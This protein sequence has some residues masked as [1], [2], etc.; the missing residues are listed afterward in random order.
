MLADMDSLERRMATLTKKT[1]GG[2]KQATADL[3]LMEKIFAGLSDGLLARAV[4][5]LT[6]TEILRLP[7]LQLQP[8]N[9]FY[10]PVMWL[11][12]T[13][14]GNGSLQKLLKSCEGAAWVYLPRLKLKCHY[15]MGSEEFISDL[16]LEEPGL[17]RLIRAGYDLLDLLT[18]LQLALKKPGPGPCAIQRP[19]QWQ[20]V[21]F[22]LIF[23][24][25]LSGQ[26]L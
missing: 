20:L 19:R 11:K 8:Q 26:R 5:G 4:S 24:A 21:S 25:A 15:L 10:M 13:A 1:R 16:G 22:I 7:Q 2:D 18:S 6:D 14:K 17:S 12:D 3:K 9:Q 23:S